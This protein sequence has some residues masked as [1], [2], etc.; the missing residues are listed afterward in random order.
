VGAFADR[1]GMPLAEDNKHGL[2]ALGPRAG[3]RVLEDTLL[4]EVVLPDFEGNNFDVAGLRGRK[5]MLLAWASW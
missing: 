4:P 1:M 5:V 3:G 2:W